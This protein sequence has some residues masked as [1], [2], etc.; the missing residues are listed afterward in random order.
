MQLGIVGNRA[1]QF[2]ERLDDGGDDAAVGLG[3]R[4]VEVQQ[5]HFHRMLCH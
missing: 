2:L 1:T 4:A 3:K 5:D